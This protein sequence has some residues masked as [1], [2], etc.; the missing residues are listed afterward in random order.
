M[1][2]TFH[3]TPPPGSRFQI[4]SGDIAKAMEDVEKLS[5]GA[6]EEEAEESE[7]MNSFLET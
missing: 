4:L 6:I 5:N 2:W 7:A 3:R 1:F